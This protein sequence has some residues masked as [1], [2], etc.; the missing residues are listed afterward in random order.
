MGSAIT[1]GFV[2]ILLPL[3]AWIVINQDWYFDVPLIDITY[4]PWRLF[5]VLCSLPALASFVIFM[6]LPESPKFVLGQGK[7][8]EAY[9]ILQ[10]MNRINNGT[11]SPLK[12]FEIF[13]EHESIE[14]RQRI[15]DSKKT[16]F[17]LLTCVWNQTAPLFKPPHL[18]TTILICT[19]QFSVM[20]TSQGFNVFYAEILNRMGINSG[21][22]KMMMC[23]IIN[24]EQTSANETY[25]QSND[26]VNSS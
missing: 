3:V 8:T 11:N 6:F 15:L 9:E 24:M 7:Q 19:I 5:L 12:K 10:K 13:E 2:C 17:P 4:K 23:D 16:K 14:N 18:F 26:A 22:E 20:Y 1:S 21:D 25:V